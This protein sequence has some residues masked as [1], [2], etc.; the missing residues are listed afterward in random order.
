MMMSKKTAIT[1][2]ATIGASLSCYASKL[3]SSFA[4]VQSYCSLFVLIAVLVLLYAWWEK[5]RP[6]RVA[7]ITC[8]QVSNFLASKKFLAIVTISFIGIVALSNI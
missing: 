6:N 2:L 8:C 1:L 3:S 4:L 7:E 5:L